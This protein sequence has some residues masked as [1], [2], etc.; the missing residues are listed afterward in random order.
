MCSSD[1]AG[2]VQ[3]VAAPGVPL[4]AAIAALGAI[5]LAMTFAAEPLFELASRGARQLLDRDEY[6][7]AVLGGA[8]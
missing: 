1:L 6:V 5:T 2:D 3:D 4:I 7:R 8:R